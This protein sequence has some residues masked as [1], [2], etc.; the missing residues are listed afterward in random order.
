MQWWLVTIVPGN[1]FVKKT[2]GCGASKFTLQW[3]I[4][5]VSHW[6]CSATMAPW[7]PKRILVGRKSC[8]PLSQQNNIQKA[9]WT[10]FYIKLKRG[11]WS[12]A[13]FWWQGG[14][15]PSSLNT[16]LVSILPKPLLEKTYWMED[17][18]ENW[19]TKLA[20]NSS[21]IY[22]DDPAELFTV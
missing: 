5:S 8:P 10:W 18:E 7:C 12:L 22:W 11:W 19:D 16:L 4:T 6:F 20:C 15:F 13:W 14:S 3:K 9:D 1:N 2:C 17:Y 21:S